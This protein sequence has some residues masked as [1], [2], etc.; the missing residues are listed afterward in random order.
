[1]TITKKSFSAMAMA[2]KQVFFPE[3]SVFSI[4]EIYQQIPKIG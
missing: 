4:A 2:T 3:P 1:M